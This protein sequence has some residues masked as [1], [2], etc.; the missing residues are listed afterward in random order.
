MNHNKNWASNLWIETKASRTVSMYV[1]RRII[2]AEVPFE[3]G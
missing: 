1:G 2:K 3:M